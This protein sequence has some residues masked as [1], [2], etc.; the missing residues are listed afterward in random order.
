MSVFIFLLRSGCVSISYRLYGD[1]YVRY[2]RGKKLPGPSQ[3]RQFIMT[4]SGESADREPYMTAVFF[5]YN[6]AVVGIRSNLIL[7]VFCRRNGFLIR[8]ATKRM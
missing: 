4:L 2:K 6:G 5:E 1:C 7:V 3:P 8:F